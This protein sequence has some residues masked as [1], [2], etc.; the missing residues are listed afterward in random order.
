MESVLEYY[1]KLAED[2]DRSRFNNSYGQF[3]HQEETRILE[4]T[5]AGINRDSILDIGCGTGRFSA[6]ASNGVDIS[7][8]MIKVAKQK[9][10]DHNYQVSDGGVIDFHDGKFQAA[11]CFHVL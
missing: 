11:F 8:Q 1:D 9:Y 2:Y 10:P 3:I 6:Y 7:P 4:T 5:L